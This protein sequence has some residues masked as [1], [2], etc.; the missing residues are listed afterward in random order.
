MLWTVYSLPLG[1]PIWLG[2]RTDDRTAPAL[3][4]G[5]PRRGSRTRED[6]YQDLRPARR[7]Q[8]RELNI[9]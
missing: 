5:N 7:H 2:T 6:Q 9:S 1:V 3:L 8:L 4:T